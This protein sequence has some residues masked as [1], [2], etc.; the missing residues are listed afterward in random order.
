[1]ILRL[2]ATE[3]LYERLAPVTKDG[4]MCATSVLIM[5][6][7]IYQFFKASVV[8]I[9]KQVQG[10]P[11]RTTARVFMSGLPVFDP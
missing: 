8:I 5:D 1:M 11:F 2:H 7:Y 9:N 3:G 6:S 10:R 4:P